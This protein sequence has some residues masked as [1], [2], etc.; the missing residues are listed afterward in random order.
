MLLF[1]MTAAAF[2]S[3]DVSFAN[4]G[5][6]KIVQLITQRDESL[7]RAVKGVEDGKLTVVD[8]GSLEEQT[9]EKSDLKAIRSNLTDSSIAKVVGVG[10]WLAWQL[11]PIFDGAE[12]R[13]TV[14]SIQQSA[15]FVT[16]N[17]YSGLMVGDAVDVFRL[18][19]PI[20]DPNSGEILE[21][22]EQK[23]AKLEVVSFSE[24]LM[25]CRATGE[26]LTELKVGDVVRPA[27]P[28]TSVAV[29]PFMNSAGQT[30]ESGMNIADETTNG[31]ANLGIP[32]LERSRTVEILGEQLRQLSLVYEG[33]DASRVGKLLGAATLVTGRLIRVKAADNRRVTMLSVRLLDVRTGT[34]LKS[35]ELELDSA[36]LN[37]TVVSTFPKGGLRRTV[38]TV[39]FLTTTNSI[40]MT[41]V[42]IP[43]GEFMM[44]SPQFEPGREQ[45][46]TEHL[47][48]LTQSFELGIHEVTQAQY[49]QVVRS[50]PSRFRGANNPVDTVSWDDATGFCRI[51]SAL[52]A[53]AAAGRS[54]RLPTEAEWEY[55]CRAGTTTAF[56]FGD[57]ER[58]LDRYAWYDKNSGPSTHP[59][60]QLQRNAWGL[61]DMHGNVWEWCYDWHAPHTAEPVRDP[62]GPQSGTGRV[63]RGGAFV[64]NASDL[65]VANRD[66]GVQETRD[67][68]GSGFRV[69]MSRSGQ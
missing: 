65:R 35:L 67:R 30:V 25:T 15:V 46:E 40:G 1:L 27:Q 60:G 57:D 47:V 9:F 59:V 61:Y 64:F 2:I 44:G 36:K 52:P 69:V 58:Q 8:V 31:L 12:K 20:K 34:I 26:F 63:I 23:I 39:T 62:Q 45:G 50:N 19:E 37:M 48:T 24:K 66:A 32:T 13:Q 68:N 38:D 53:E 3:D 54:Y 7:Y 17:P 16:G 41:F 55:A 21:A 56:S 28:R 49:Q 51:L 14:A 6:R 11:Q 42:A 5:E 4:L 22:P 29:L 18:G 10:S 33:G 43:A